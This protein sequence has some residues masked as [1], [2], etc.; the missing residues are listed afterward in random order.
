MRRI[1]LP[2]P[3]P[4]RRMKVIGPA[5]R[6]ACRSKQGATRAFENSIRSTADCERDEAREDGWAI[7]WGGVLFLSGNS[8]ETSIWATDDTGGRRSAEL[9]DEHLQAAGFVVHVSGKAH[10]PRPEFATPLVVRREDSL[11]G[12]IFWPKLG[13]EIDP[14]A[15]EINWEHQH[16]WKVQPCP[17]CGESVSP[18]IAI[19]GYPS[20]SA[21]LQIAL[22]D[23][24]ACGCMFL[25][26][27]AVCPSCMA[28][29]HAT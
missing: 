10:T 20:K 23:A 9:L 22:G 11:L 12:N 15:D 8:I 14:D 13:Y 19:R 25:D 18:R 17:H 2:K 3:K 27:N 1:Q 16:R 6:R 26:G 4:V 7:W 21:E 24:I 29:F 28:E 5:G